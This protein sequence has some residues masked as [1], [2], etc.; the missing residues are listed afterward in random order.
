MRLRATEH[1]N[2]IIGPVRDGS[3]RPNLWLLVLKEIRLVICRRLRLEA[4]PPQHR[5]PSAPSAF[6]P[7]RACRAC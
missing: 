1:L 6:L 3:P 2:V 7:P 4:R 5:S